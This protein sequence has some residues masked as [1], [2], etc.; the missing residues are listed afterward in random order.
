MPPPRFTSGSILRHVI[1][2]ATTGAVGLVAIFVVDLLNLFYLSLLGDHA[3]AAAIGFAGVVAFFQTALCIGLMIGLGAVVSHEIGAGQAA[4]ARHLA[5]S[6]LLV[7]AAATAVVGVAAAFAATPLVAKLGATGET[8]AFAVRFL[9]ISA[10]SLPLLG[11]GM[12]LTTLLRAAGDAGAAMNLTLLTALSAACLDPLLI[13]VLHLGVAGAALSTVL[14]RLVLAI[15]AW[16]SAAQRQGLVGTVVADQFGHDLRTMLTVAVPAIL[17]NLATPVGSAWVTRS[18]AAFGP[19]AV[20]GQATIDRI[21]PVA[22][23]LRLRSVGRDRPHPGAEPWRG[24]GPTGCVRRC[25]TAWPSPS[26]RCWSPGPCW[27]WRRTQCCG[28]SRRKA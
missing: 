18:M 12:G 25:A 15:A 10:P 19:A 16:R 4:Q 24:A 5:A 3:I 28:L 11:L 26:P 21:A 8:R 6:G 20:A 7:I 13:F 17:T 14:S 22:F 23:A 2:M 27:H 1:V 9:T